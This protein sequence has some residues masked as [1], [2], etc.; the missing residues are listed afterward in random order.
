MV[1][2]SLLLHRHE[3]GIYHKKGGKIVLLVSLQLSRELT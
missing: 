3:R 1:K 2:V